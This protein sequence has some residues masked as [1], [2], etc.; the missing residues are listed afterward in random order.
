MGAGKGQRNGYANLRGMMQLGRRRIFDVCRV[1]ATT[2]ALRLETL[3]GHPLGNEA[4][5][6]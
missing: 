2:P 5:Y 1:P 6:A 3:T 4:G